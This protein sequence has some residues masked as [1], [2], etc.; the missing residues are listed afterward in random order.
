MGLFKKELF[1]GNKQKCLEI[2]ALLQSNGIRCTY[3]IIKRNIIPFNSASYL[4]VKN[5]SSNI[6]RVLVN[7]KDFDQAVMLMNQK[8]R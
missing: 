7:K 5:S 3:K 2:V 6:A 1:V 4:I 8:S